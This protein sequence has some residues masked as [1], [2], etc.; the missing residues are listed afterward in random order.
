MRATTPRGRRLA[1]IIAAPRFYKVPHF[2]KFMNSAGSP[3]WRP[4]P[5]V[6]ALSASPRRPRGGVELVAV[7]PPRNPRAPSRRGRI[8]RLWRPL[9]APGAAPGR[10]TD[11][12]RVPD[13]PRR[14][15]PAAPRPTPWPPGRRSS[16]CPNDKPPPPRPSFCRRARPKATCRHGLPR[17]R[18]R[19]HGS[20]EFPPPWIA[21]GRGA[22]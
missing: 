20:A 16:P 6:A 11:A 14:P 9:A 2:G 5:G 19:I 10:R 1:R 17:P 13:G 12:A 3:K 22:G 8:R 18:T 7:W 21:A 15:V 4:V